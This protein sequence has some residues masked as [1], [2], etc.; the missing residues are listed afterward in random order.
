MYSIHKIIEV[1]HATVLQLA[2]EATITHLA[3]DS[4]RIHFPKETLFF[5]IIADR[6]DG[7]D[8]IAQAYNKGVRNFIIEKEMDTLLF[9]EASFLLVP[10]SIE[11]L[12][13]I[14]AQHRQQFTIPIIGITGS[15]GKTIVKEWL[16]QLL[17]NDYNIVRSPKSYNSQIGVALSVFN[18]AAHHTL[19]IFEAGISTT[20]EMSQLQKIIQPTIG[21]LTNIG[22]A[23]SDGFENDIEKL[24]EKLKLFTHSEILIYNEDATLIRTEVAKLNCKK[25]SWGKAETGVIKIVSQEKINGHTNLN[26]L[27]E[28]KSLEFSIPFADDA[29]IENAMHCIAAC[30]YFKMDVPVLNK[31][32]QQLEPVAMRLEQKKG[33]HNCTIIN[34]SYSN[35]LSSLQIALDY[36]EQQNSALSRTVIL[37]DL[38]DASLHADTAYNT[39]AQLLLQKKCTK[40]IGIGITIATYKNLFGKIGSC[41]F[42]STIEE[43]LHDF[44]PNSFHN[45]AILIKGARKFKIDEL[46]A[47]LEEKVHQTVLEVHLDKV[48]ENIK[49]HQQLLNPSTQIMAIVKAFGYGN[50]ATEVATVLQNLN[51]NYLA[52]AYTDEGVALRKSG[53]HLPIMVMNTDEA[54]FHALVEN[55]L[56]PEIYSFAILDSFQHFAKQNALVDYPIHIKLDTGMHRLGFE[57]QDIEQLC[58][59]LKGNNFFQVQTIF[60]H[61]VGSEAEDLDSFTQEQNNLFIE[62]A[63]TIEGAIGYKTIK[64]IANS[65]AIER[66]PHLQH[67]MVR[68]GIGMYGVTSNENLVLQQTCTLKTTIAQIKHLK[69]GETVGYSRRGKLERDSIIATVRIGYADGYN[70]KLGN[71]KG[72]MLVNGALA[73]TIGSI[74]MD[75]TMIDITDIPNVS[76]GEYVIVLGEALP[77]QQ[78]ATWCE[79]IPYEILTGISQRVKRI[80]YGD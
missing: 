42:Y 32:L 24:Q 8:F 78:I 71:G 28:D 66:H 62:L 22:K 26:I 20:N 38:G 14:A 72:K 60:S 36:L 68:L 5:A 35:D 31:S 39:V 40:F 15:N 10:N 18:V 55:D 48:I 3:I 52:V 73:P 46:A 74:C 64:H 7:H 25:L 43:A 6:R 16:Y 2:Q 61:L 9:P 34:D 29:Y 49:A 70:R 44:N 56:E 45:E 69:K 57:A 77:V 17:Q 27:Y 51:C 53:I 50:G 37:T 11:A 79:T 4:R 12:Q 59:H 1:T 54:A 19:G 80:Y 75:M 47:L 30:L 58:T 13:L 63:T 65:A 33:I 76:E 67:E 21:I 41:F 23:H